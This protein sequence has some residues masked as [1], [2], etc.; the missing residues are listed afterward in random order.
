MRG[1]KAFSINRQ[2]L[3]QKP[4]NL[5]KR[6]LWFLARDAFLCIIVLVLLAVV[7]G[8]FLLYH[9]VLSIDI[10]EVS[11]DNNV[12][13]FKDDTYASIVSQWK[14]QEDVFNKPLETIY[15]NPFR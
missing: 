2:Q 15:K 12:I 13:G 1:F 10:K 6:I 5:M 8:E 7:F 9:D 3:W 4:V 11:D 14:D